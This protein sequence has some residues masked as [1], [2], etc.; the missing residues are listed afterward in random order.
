VGRRQPLLEVRRA[1]DLESR[2]FG[3]AKPFLELA[4]IGKITNKSLRGGL[5]PCP[6]F[7][8]GAETVNTAS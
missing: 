7:T 8:G 6:G 5:F 1:L 4:G 3:R 2:A